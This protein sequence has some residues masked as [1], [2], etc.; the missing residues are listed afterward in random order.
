MFKTIE[1]DRGNLTIIGVNFLDL[2]SV[3]EFPSNI[4]IYLLHLVIPSLFCFV[5]SFFYYLQHRDLRMTVWREIKE[6]IGWC[7]SSED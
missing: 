5:Q 4:Y 1:I 6:V 3:N 2:K 7:R